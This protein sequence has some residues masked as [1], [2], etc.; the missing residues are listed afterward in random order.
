MARRLR[1]IGLN[2]PSSPQGSIAST[3]TVRRM[4]FISGRAKRFWTYNETLRRPS[5]AEVQR[6]NSAGKS[7]PVDSRFLGAI[8][9]LA[10]RVCRSPKSKSQPRPRQ[11]LLNL[12]KRRT[13]RIQPKQCGTR[14]GRKKATAGAPTIAPKA[15]G[16]KRTSASRTGMAAAELPTQAGRLS[17]CPRHGAWKWA[18]DR[19]GLQAA[20]H[21]FPFPFLARRP[22]LVQQIADNTFV[23]ARSIGS[24]AARLEHSAARPGDWWPR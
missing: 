2:E 3:R 1:K 8:G 19:S 18:P 20:S 11:F 14:G 6:W 9:E 10:D 17:P 21:W 22:G 23:P 13:G 5:G 12:Y 16:L 4:M 15:P 24:A 7:I